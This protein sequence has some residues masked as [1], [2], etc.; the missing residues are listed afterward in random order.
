MDVVGGVPSLTA[1][2]SCKE[3]K[4]LTGSSTAVLNLDKFYYALQFHG[5][6][7][8]LLSLS[9]SLSLSLSGC[10]LMDDVC[11]GVLV[12]GGWLVGAGDWSWLR[13]RHIQPY[14]KANPNHNPDSLTDI[15]ANPGPA[16]CV[17]SMRACFAMAMGCVV[18]CCAVGN[19]C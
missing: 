16:V 3:L 13:E 19:V 7:I 15:L 10:E 4:D 6:A 17:C 5:L 1:N 18:L 2:F 8:T 14:L 9:V 12:V 11:M